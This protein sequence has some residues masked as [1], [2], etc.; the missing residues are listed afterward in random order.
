M[1]TFLDC[2]VGAKH[3]LKS[4]SGVNLPFWAALA[5]E[6]DGGTPPQTRP[7]IIANI[8]VDVAAAFLGARIPL[9]KFDHP[10][11]A[12]F[13][14]KY[15]QV[16]GCVHEAS[17]LRKDTMI[18]TVTVYGEHSRAIRRRRTHEGLKEVPQTWPGF[19][20]RTDDY[21]NAIVDVLVGH[22]SEAYGVRRWKRSAGTP[23]HFGTHG[24]WR[25]P[26]DIHSGCK[27]VVYGVRLW[28]KQGVPLPGCLI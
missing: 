13:L 21:G 3:L 17:T 24:G 7:E 6:S 12:E 9:E 14:K 2:F 16:E 10:S 5:K 25:L 27:Y 19:D 11:I 20:E 28:W 22:G 15:T 18:L 26:L 8:N 4:K 23:P 1:F